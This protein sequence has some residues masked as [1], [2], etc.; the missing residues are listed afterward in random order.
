MCKE[1]QVP[2]GLKINTKRGGFEYIPW[3]SVIRITKQPDF[4][5]ITTW[6]V[7]KG[8]PTVTYGFTGDSAGKID[9]AIKEGK[10]ERILELDE[11][12]ILGERATS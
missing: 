12:D 10:S 1:L 11:V 8:S 4:I 6:S 5:A 9:L 7:I 2:S 3:Q